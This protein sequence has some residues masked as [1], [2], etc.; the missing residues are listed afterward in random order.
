MIV[1]VEELNG[2]LFRL[3]KDE[4]DSLMTGHSYNLK[5][6]AKMKKICHLLKYYEYVDMDDSDFMKIA[7][8]YE[9]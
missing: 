2:V 1:A 4:L 6:I 5:R 3:L 7:R 8:F 9:Y